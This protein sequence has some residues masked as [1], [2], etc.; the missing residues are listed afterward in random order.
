MKE[1]LIEEFYL[2]KKPFTDKGLY[3]QPDPVKVYSSG[4]K[5]W[6]IVSLYK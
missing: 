1:G 3:N 6:I 2:N 5:I 4:S